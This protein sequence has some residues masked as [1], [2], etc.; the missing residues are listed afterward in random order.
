MFNLNLQ[1]STKYANVELRLIAWFIDAL[2]L[3][4]PMLAGIY[5]LLS[6][7]SLVNLTTTFVSF[8]AYL[9]FP[10]L[11]LQFTYHFFTTSTWGKT[12]GKA[13]VGL[14]V[15][16][17]HGRLLT[18]S[19]AFMRE[20]VTK[21]VSAVLLGAG[22][23]AAAFNK[24]HQGWHDEFVGSYVYKKEPRLWFGLV[25][26]FGLFLFYG[27]ASVQLFQLVINSPLLAEIQSYLPQ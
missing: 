27:F 8:V 13:V 9:F 20:N 7:P 18:K 14:E 5:W 15:A 12:I 4:L 24:D 17:E 1:H 3:S 25:V 16:D 10:M 19:E 11:F 23:W 2:V 22:F 6:Q 21:S 26:V